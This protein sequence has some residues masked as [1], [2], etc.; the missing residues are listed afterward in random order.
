MV[1]VIMMVMI[2]DLQMCVEM[3]QVLGIRSF[4]A[5]PNAICRAEILMTQMTCRVMFHGFLPE[6]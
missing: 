6:S 1:T 4:H 5:C 2:I 3:C